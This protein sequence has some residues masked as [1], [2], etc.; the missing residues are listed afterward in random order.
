MEQLERYQ[1]AHY[2]NTTPSANTENWVLEGVGVDALSIAYNPQVDQYRQI[3]DKNSS[4]NFQ[5]Y[6][7]QSS[8]SGKRIFKDDAM[9]EFLDTAR[10]NAKSI[11]TQYIEVDMAYETSSKYQATKYDIL[12]VINEFLGENATISY[13]IYFRG[14]PVQGMVSISNNTITFE[15]S[16]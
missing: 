12:I 15:E 7:I 9:Y 4:A 3:I 11:E 13:D 1:F 14:D 10:R 5:G 2:I 16:Q 8:I 6:Q